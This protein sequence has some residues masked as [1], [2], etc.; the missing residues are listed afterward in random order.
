MNKIEAI[1]GT[2]FREALED[3]LYRMEN[4]TNRNFGTEQIGQRFYELG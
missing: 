4:G 2:R 1:Y 3:I